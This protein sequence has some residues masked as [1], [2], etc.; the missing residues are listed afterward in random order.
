MSP[1]IVILCVV[2]PVDAD[3]T[4]AI[5]CGIVRVH[6]GPAAT[7]DTDVEPASIDAEFEVLS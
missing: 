3:T 5:P 4:Q 2:I 7:V 1:I 6:E